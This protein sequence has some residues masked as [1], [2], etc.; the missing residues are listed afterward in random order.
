MLGEVAG[1][2]LVLIATDLAGD[3]LEAGEGVDDL[4]AVAA[5]DLIL[6][7]G[8]HE[9]LHQRDTIGTGLG[10][11]AELLISGKTILGHQGTD[12]VAGDEVH[13]AVPAPHRGAHA[14]AIGVGGHD[15]IESLFLGQLD[16]ER[17]RVGVLRVG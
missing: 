12:L 17:K 9:G 3:P 4:H 7:C 11:D 5:R 2:E 6:Q 13:L 15:E 10:N 1:L 8:G 16:C 14:V